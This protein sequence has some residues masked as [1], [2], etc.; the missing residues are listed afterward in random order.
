MMLSNNRQRIVET[1]IKITKSKLKENNQA[2]TFDFREIQKCTLQVSIS[3][4]LRK[5]LLTGV[6]MQFTLTYCMWRI[7]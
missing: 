3:K 2:S 1:P 6:Q 7:D 5:R 4:L